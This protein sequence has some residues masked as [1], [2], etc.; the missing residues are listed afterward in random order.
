[1]DAPIN[2]R[3]LLE[4]ASDAIGYWEPRRLIYNAV[5]TAV[6]LA[7]FALGYPDSRA[8][9]SINLALLV[10]V[11]A[12]L[13]NVAYCA[14]YLADLFIQMSEYR[15]RWRDNRWILFSV[16]LLVA[17]VLTHFWALGLFRPV[18]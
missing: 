18:V 9:L 5:L 13:A 14:A 8:A 12:V 10:F 16:G 1:M 15:D 2:T 6:V 11:L 4:S 17:G 3:V 7:H